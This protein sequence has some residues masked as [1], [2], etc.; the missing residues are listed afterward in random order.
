MKAI[1]PA[2][3][4]SLDAACDDGAGPD[5]GRAR[6]SEQIETLF[7]ILSRQAIRRGA[8]AQSRT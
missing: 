5:R 1:L 6:L 7:G 4:I 2:R 8:F 3:D